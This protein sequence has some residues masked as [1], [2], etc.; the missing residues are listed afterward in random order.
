MYVKTNLATHQKAL[1]SESWIRELEHDGDARASVRLSLPDH[2]PASGQ[3]TKVN[4]LWERY[5]DLTVGKPIDGQAEL[6]E[7]RIFTLTGLG[8]RGL[9]TAPLM[10][11]VLASQLLHQPMPMPEKLLQAVAPQRFMIRNCI[12]GEA[13]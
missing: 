5:Q 11:Q 6:P 13:P 4:V 7:G 10:A 12:R 1:S 8:S 2:Q 9:T 3:L